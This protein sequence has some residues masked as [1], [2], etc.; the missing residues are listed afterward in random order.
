MAKRGDV[1]PCGDA[2]MAD[3]V[4]AQ[5]IRKAVN[6]RI[7]AVVIARGV[8]GAPVGDNTFVVGFM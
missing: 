4:N 8:F 2:A 5:N 3:A 7:V 1:A 6:K